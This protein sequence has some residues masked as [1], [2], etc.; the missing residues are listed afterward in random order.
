LL[1]A[2]TPIEKKNEQLL[3]RF[4][5]SIKSEVSQVNVIDYINAYMRHWHLY[6]E[7]EDVIL[8]S[9]PGACNC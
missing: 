5:W 2:S 3:E 9:I 4:I 6:E 8:L 1:Q 7:E